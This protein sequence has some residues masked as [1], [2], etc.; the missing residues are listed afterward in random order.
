MRPEQLADRYGSPS[1]EEVEK[2]CRAF[3][4]DFEAA[5]G[6][7]EAGDVEIEVSSP[8]RLSGRRRG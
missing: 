1:M 3:N 6:E 2:F 8:V 5:L 4:A 7:E